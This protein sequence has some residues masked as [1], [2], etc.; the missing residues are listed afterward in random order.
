M[1]AA[2]ELRSGMVVDLEGVRLEVDF[3]GEQ[4]AVV[5]V[6]VGTGRYVERV[7]EKKGQGGP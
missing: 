7:K 5:R 2:A 3:V 6:H 4:A 1:V